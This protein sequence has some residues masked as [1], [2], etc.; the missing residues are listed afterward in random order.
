MATQKST[1][2]FQPDLAGPAIRAL[3]SKL[4]PAE[5]IKNPIMFAVEIGTVMMGLVTAYIAL[6]CDT[7]Q[8]SLSCNSVITAVLLPFANFAEAIAEARGKTLVE[9]VRKT[10]Q[11]TPAKIIRPAPAVRRGQRSDCP[12]RP[13]SEYSGCA[14]PAVG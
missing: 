6:S 7:S 13:C 11:E 5:L 12:Y 14:A 10:R 9:S 3:F 2:L 4:N 8:G 1:A